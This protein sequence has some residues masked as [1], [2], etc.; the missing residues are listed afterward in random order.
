MTFNYGKIIKK[1][2]QTNQFSQLDEILK[3]KTYK[4]IIKFKH[5]GQEIFINILQYTCITGNND[6]FNYVLNKW[7]LSEN[8]KKNITDTNFLLHYAAEGGN[9]D[10][11][12]N[13]IVNFELNVNSLDSK[14]FTPLHYAARFNKTEMVKLLLNEGANSTQGNKNFFTPIHEAA[15]LGYTEIMN[16]L[17]EEH[18]MR[19]LKKVV[20]IYSCSPL[21]YA[22]SHLQLDAVKILLGSNNPHI[23]FDP[24][25]KDT[26][27]KDVLD[28]LLSK[29]YYNAEEK[30]TATE[31]AKL[32]LPKMNFS[33]NNKRSKALT[34]KA[35]K[36]GLTVIK[37][38]IESAFKGEKDFSKFFIDEDSIDTDMESNDKEILKSKTLKIFPNEKILPNTNKRSLTDL[39]D[40]PPAKK[41]SFIGY[42]ESLAPPPFPAAFEKAN[43][44]TVAS[45]QPFE[46]PMNYTGE[47]YTI[48]ETLDDSTPAFTE[49]QP[50]LDASNNAI[51]VLP[52]TQ[53]SHT[54]YE[55]YQLDLN[56]NPYPDSETISSIS[57]KV[58]SVK[59]FSSGS[60]LT[61]SNSNNE[62]AISESTNSQVPLKTSAG[63]NLPSPDDIFKLDIDE[64]Y[65][66]YCLN[67]E[68][69]GI[70]PI[71]H[72]QTLLHIDENDD[73]DVM[74]NQYVGKEDCK[75]ILPQGETTKDNLPYPWDSFDD[76]FNKL[77]ED[78]LSYAGE[79]TEVYI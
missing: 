75:D 30:I 68:S 69:D 37:F 67:N 31:I 59:D 63:R 71:P 8:D 53:S 43:D 29:N 38:M 55:D 58:S 21:H 56:I 14:G 20:D 27:E 51:P 70:K 33:S 17:L 36:L 41:A 18:D 64:L 12:K 13:V 10:I 6:A 49:T 25:N 11:A 78:L 34:N 23:N 19:Q 57:E 28:Y 26:N 5:N 1:I 47:D 74:Y 24:K 46:L 72:S 66:R 48:F 61:L 76:L 40:T 15:K 60:N 65:N 3:T 79:D 77:N 45:E 16:I 7:K 54:T 52:I 32:I 4:D 44:S 39:E 35:T 50:S 2:L 73:L 42:D 22:A 62:V 9:P